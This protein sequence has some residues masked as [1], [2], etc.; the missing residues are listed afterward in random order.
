MK[1]L[2]DAEG[3]KRK[4][5]QTVNMESWYVTTHQKITQTK[6]NCFQVDVRYL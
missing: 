6:E 5:K 4:K 1:E 3:R 2:L